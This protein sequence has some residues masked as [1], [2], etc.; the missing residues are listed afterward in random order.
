MKREQITDKSRMRASN[1]T[2]MYYDARS[3]VCEAGSHFTR[4]IV[5]KRVIRLVCHPS[6]D[7]NGLIVNMLS[8]LKET[9]DETWNTAYE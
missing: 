7:A 1:L 6:V 2:I 4:S 9:F 3:I 8:R 5:L